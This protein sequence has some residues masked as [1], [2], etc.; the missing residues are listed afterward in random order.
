MAHTPDHA[1]RLLREL[2]PHLATA[3]DEVLERE[4]YHD[5]GFCD[6]FLAHIEDLIFRLT[7]HVE[8][9]ATG[10][11]AQAILG[12]DD[13]RRLDEALDHLRKARQLA[14]PRQGVQKSRIYWVEG[15][16]L[17]RRGRTEPCCRVL[18]VSFQRTSDA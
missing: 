15:M 16:A 12:L 9:S 10:N 7:P 1:R 11:L 13:P 18:L 17:I 14:G 8:L 6:R 5:P 2:E 4:C 3:A